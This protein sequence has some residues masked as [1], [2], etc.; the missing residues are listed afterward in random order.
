MSRC[1]CCSNIISYFSAVVSAENPSFTLALTEPIVLVGMF[2][3]FVYPS[4][5]SITMTAVGDAA[6]EMINEIRRKREY[7]D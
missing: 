1:T 7:L 5:S 3:E 2:I 6:F 4:V